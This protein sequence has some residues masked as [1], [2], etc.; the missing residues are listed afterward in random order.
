MQEGTSGS[1]VGRPPATAGAKNAPSVPS[2]PFSTAWPPEILAG[3]RSRTAREGLRCARLMKIT[4]YAAL[5]LLAA[6]FA[7]EVT[8]AEQHCDKRRHP[9]VDSVDSWMVAKDARAYFYSAR[10]DEPGA[11]TRLK[12]YI[13][14]GDVVGVSQPV[15]DLRTAQDP[16]ACAVYYGADG[17]R[18]YGWLRKSDLLVL[19]GFLRRRMDFEDPEPSPELENVLSQ[20]PPVQSWSA[21]GVTP[22]P[23]YHE[24]GFI[25]NFICVLRL[26]LDRKTLCI[27]TTHRPFGPPDCGQLS[28]GNRYARFDEEGWYNAYLLNNA[29]AIVS[30]PEMW[31]NHG[32]SDPEGV[33]VF[34]ASADRACPAH[35]APP[36][37]G[38]KR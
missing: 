27:A 10:P 31:G 13:V 8:Q 29:I 24:R 32:Q 1:R 12:S 7:A 3:A 18:S 34:S 30:Q 33:Y 28:L 38:R 35:I 23:C 20:L 17:M 36:L 2:D 26:D 37:P 5:G 6:V 19:G 21:A 22:V 14:R 4:R 15:D 11:P 25:G 9:P 16:F